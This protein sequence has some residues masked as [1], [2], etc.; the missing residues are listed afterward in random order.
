M[1]STDRDEFFGDSRCTAELDLCEDFEQESLDTGIWSVRGPAPTID[2][3][4]AARGSRSAHF[5]TVDNGLSYIEQSLSF[6]APGNR[7]FARIFV[8]FDSMPSAPEWAHWSIAGAIGSGTEAEIRVGGQYDNSINRFGVGSDYGPTGDWTNLDEDPGGSPSEVP[9]D[10]WLCVEWLHDGGANETRF[11]WDGV[12]HPSLFTS[13]VE[14]GGDDNEPYVLPEFESVWVGWLLYQ[15]NTT[16]GEFDV[17]ID[18]VAFDDE[19][20]GC[21]R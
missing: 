2:E 19:R 5:H 1:Y 10:E 8:Y 4:R 17:W 15:S 13:A 6:P 18:E 12:E 3:S 20:I 7:Y 11:W 9:V 21:S 14:H 16:P